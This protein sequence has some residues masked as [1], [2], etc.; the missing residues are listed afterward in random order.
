MLPN[1]YSSGGDWGGGWGKRQKK[2]PGK[3]GWKDAPDAESTRTVLELLRNN[4]C[5]G[6]THSVVYHSIP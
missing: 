2:G 6:H 3:Q 5:Y 4:R 1:S